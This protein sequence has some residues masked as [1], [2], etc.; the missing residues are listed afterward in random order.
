MNTKTIIKVKIN[1][2]LLLMFAITGCMRVEPPK[3]IKVNPNPA[4]KYIVK[5]QLEKDIGNIHDVVTKKRYSVINVETCSP[6]DQGRSI[7]GS[8]NTIDKDISERLR[9][10]NKNLFQTLYIPDYFLDESYYLLE[11]CNWVGSDVIFEF[12]KNNV[13]Y[14]AIYLNEDIISGKRLTL[15]CESVKQNRQNGGSEYCKQFTNN[16]YGL[17]NSYFEVTLESKKI[18]K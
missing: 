2:T 14:A 8:W 1:Q 3:D 18:S 11:K 10:S 6:K 5:M 4:E 16:D 17:V 13:R 7:G 9:P 12:M 15:Q